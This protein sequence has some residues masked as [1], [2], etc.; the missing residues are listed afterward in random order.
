[1]F[2]EQTGF[3]VPSVPLLLGVGALSADGQFSFAAALLIAL[4]ASLPADA[5]WYQLGKRRGYG[6]L[7]VLCRISLEADSCVKRT[8]TIFQRYGLGTLVLAKFIPGL[9]T[10]APPM[11][12]MLKMSTTRFILLDGA[13]ATL[14]ATAYLALGVVFR[15]ELEWIAATVAHTGASLVAIIVLTFGSYLAW[16]WLDRRRYLHKLEMA[17]MLPEELWRRIQAG[18]DITILDLRHPPDVKAHGGVIP[19][20]I[21]FPPEELDTRY[22]EIPREKDIAL[23]C[24]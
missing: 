5:V 11:A 24:S 4:L 12:G 8:T 16:K 1:V 13:G 3:P 23:Y 10:V 17:R 6:V 9:S 21:R 14:W 18:E 20:A 19:G 22:K 7:R 2:L 15:N